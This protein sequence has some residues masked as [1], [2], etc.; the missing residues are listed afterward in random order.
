MASVAVIDIGSNSI[1]VLVAARAAGDG[2]TVLKTRTIDARISAGISHVSPA[3]ST[4]ITTKLACHPRRT[5]N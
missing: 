5:C 3:A 1:K 2:L 4:A